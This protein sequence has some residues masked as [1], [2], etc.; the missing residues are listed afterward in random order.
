LKSVRPLVYTLLYDSS[1]KVA[2]MKF[3]NGVIRYQNLLAS[4]KFRPKWTTCW[5]EDIQNCKYLCFIVN[6]YDPRSAF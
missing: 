5:V 4:S 1:G 2:L 6:L 3:H